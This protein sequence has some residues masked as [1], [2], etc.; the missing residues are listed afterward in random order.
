MAGGLVAGAVVLGL[1]GCGGSSGSGP[2]I[3]TIAP[4]KVFKL[5]DF[6][7]AGTV[8][9][10]RPVPVS[11]TVEQPSGE[12]LTSYRKGPGPHTGV[13]LIAVRTDLSLIIHQHPPVAADGRVS[14][15]VV[16]PK[17][18]TYRVLVDIYPAVAGAPRNLQLYETVHVAGTARPEPLGPFEP[19][20]T[21]DG[22]R[23]TVLGVP[24]LKAIEPAYLKIRITDPRGKPARLQLYYGALAHAIFFRQGTLD[25]FH[26][27]VCPPGSSACA[28]FGGLPTGTPLEPGLLKVGVLMPIGGTWRLFLQVEVGGRIITA[29]YTL[30]VAPA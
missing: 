18:G 6:E 5:V 12:P 8:Q 20:Q 15:L 29:P 2:A 16:F 3:P 17:P 19:V 21:V 24:E 4:A 11:F 28:G 23:F 13:H 10:G 22:Y 14:Q 1:T 9:P 30:K 26:T 27:H 7:P 25:Y